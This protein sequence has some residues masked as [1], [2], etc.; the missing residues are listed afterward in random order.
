MRMPT[1]RIEKLEHMVEDG[2]APSAMHVSP[3]EGGLIQDTA[4]TVIEEMR[5]QTRQ[6]KLHYNQP[7]S[8]IGDVVLRPCVAVIGG[9]AGLFQ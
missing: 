3:A 8:V 9:R 7:T 1:L 5:G 2:Y 4:L 6:L